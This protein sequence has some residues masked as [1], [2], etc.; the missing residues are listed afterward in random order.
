MKGSPC[1]SLFWLA[2]SGRTSF[3]RLINP[4]SNLLLR[5]FLFCHYDMGYCCNNCY[6]L[7]NIAKYM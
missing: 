4:L 1:G 7:A 3:E 5:D 6:M 2:V